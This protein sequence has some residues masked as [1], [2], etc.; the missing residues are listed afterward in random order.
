MTQR[1]ES[2]QIWHRWPCRGRRFADPPR[3][4]REHRA[5]PGRRL[6]RAEP[7]ETNTAIGARPAQR[8]SATGLDSRRPLR[9]GADLVARA[10]ARQATVAVMVSAPRARRTETRWWPSRIA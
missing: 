6:A 3:D 10:A 5:A 1:P 9:G 8:R 7:A 2:P 4:A